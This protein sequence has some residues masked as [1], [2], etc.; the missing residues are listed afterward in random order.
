MSSI[1]KYGIK[2]GDYLYLLPGMFKCFLL[3]YRIPSANKFQVASQTTFGFDIVFMINKETNN[4]LILFPDA[5]WLA[6]LKASK[7]SLS[8]ANNPNS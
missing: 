4:L 2:N 8:S 1:K 5:R 6:S 3:W 7:N